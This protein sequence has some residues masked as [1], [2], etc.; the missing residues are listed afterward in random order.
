MCNCEL[1][2]CLS[3]SRHNPGAGG[4]YLWCAIQAR[5]VK[6]EASL[7]RW[8]ENNRGVW[9]CW[10]TMPLLGSRYSENFDPSSTLLTSPSDHRVLIPAYCPFHYPASHT[11]LLSDHPIHYYTCAFQ[12]FLKNINKAFWETPAS[13]W[14]DFNNAGLRWVFPLPWW[15]DLGSHHSLSQAEGPDLSPYVL[16]FSLWPA[17]SFFSL[18]SHVPL[19]PLQKFHTDES[20]MRTQHLEFSQHNMHQ[21]HLC[22]LLLELWYTLRNYALWTWSATCGSNQD[23][24]CESVTKEYSQLLVA[25][26]RKQD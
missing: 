19:L 8:I 16:S 17:I 13:F 9:M 7:S 18:L 11:F 12:P 14:D 5:R 2:S 4:V 6:C 1:I 21:F 22:L 20:L 23:I 3:L 26:P 24:I 15:K 25:I 10:S